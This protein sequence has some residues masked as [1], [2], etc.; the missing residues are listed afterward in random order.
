MSTPQLLSGEDGKFKVAKDLRDELCILDD[1]VI[2]V[3]PSKLSDPVVRSHIARAT[4]AFMNQ[5]IRADIRSTDISTIKEAYANH[6]TKQ[7]VEIDTSRMQRDAIQIFE[8]A[9]SQSA[10]DIHIRIDEE[11]ADMLFRID[12]DLVHIRELSVDYAKALVQSIYVSLT[13]TSSDTVFKENGRQDARIADKKRLP[14]KL[15]GLRLATTPTVHGMLMVMRLLYNSDNGSDIVSLGYSHDHLSQVSLMMSQPYG[16]N[17]IS[18]P[19]GSGKSTTLQRLLAR[20]FEI[21]RGQ[22]NI[23]TVEDP[24]E[25]PILGAVQTPV[26]AESE[27]DRG[28]AFRSAIRSCMRLDPDIMM[29]G[30]VRDRESAQLAINAAMTGHQLW[31]TIHANNAMA[32]FDRL[33]EIGI[34]LGTICDPALITGLTAQRLVKKLCKHCRIPLAQAERTGMINRNLERRLHT[35]LEEDVSDVYVRNHKGCEHCRAGAAGRTVVAEIIIPDA[36]FCDLMRAG[37]RTKAHHY[38]MHEQKGK[39]MLAHAIS[40]IR[41]G[42]VDPDDAER[43][44]GPL[45]MGLVTNDDTLQMH[46]VTALI[47]NGGLHVP[48]SE[49]FAL[50]VEG[51]GLDDARSATPEER[52]QV[53]PENEPPATPEPA[54]A[55]GAM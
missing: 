8:D 44:L 21:T 25:Y 38:W 26:V 45:T 12:G 28:E 51:L 7:T 3:T 32:I 40:K 2:L 55:T 36:K 49:E 6:Q 47:G 13:D 39:S 52:A 16:I 41:S 48:L 37:E 20:L 10:S 15:H 17:L 27:A 18:G 1:G 4:R 50:A 42:E 14:P 9:V 34:P 54:V 5:N 11:V 30:E 35:A 29:I 43:E 33:I 31:T 22:K 19:T 46:E 23:M 53:A 24:P